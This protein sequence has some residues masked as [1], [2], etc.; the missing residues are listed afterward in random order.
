MKIKTVR[1]KNPDNLNLI[2]GQSHFIKTVEDLHEALVSS[3]PGIKFGLAFAEASGPRLI[4]TSGTDKKLVKLASDNLKKIGAGH[5][6]LIFLGNCFPINVLGSIKRV[7]E[8][9]SIFCSTANVVEVVV[10]QGRSNNAVLGVVDG[11]GPKGVE[12]KKQ[13][14]ERKDF[15]RKIGYKL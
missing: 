9:V 6:F 10:Y 7:S 1:I 8:V 15:I 4:R 12:N 3:V 13:E 5:S 14:K 11:G 2:F